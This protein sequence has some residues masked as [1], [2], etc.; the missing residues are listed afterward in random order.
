MSLMSIK[1]QKITWTSTFVTD[2]HL[3]VVF[4]TNVFF[5]QEFVINKIKISYV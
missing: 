4:S 2:N 1:K 5:L 3:L